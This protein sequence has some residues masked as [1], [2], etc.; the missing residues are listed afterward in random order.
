[1]EIRKPYTQK[2]VSIDF[3]KT[4]SRTKQ[5]HAKE[6]D[7][8]QIMAKFQKTGIVTHLANY[9]GQYGDITSMD[10]KEAMDTVV[11]AQGMFDDLPSSI[12]N[13]FA[14]DPTQFMDFIQNPTNDPQIEAEAVELGLKQPKETIPVPSEVTTETTTETSTP[15]AEPTA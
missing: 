14:N 11:R 8:N 10:F 13:R 1:M 3:S 12:R 2:T 7:I 6:C 4:K 5:S 15:T 9:Q